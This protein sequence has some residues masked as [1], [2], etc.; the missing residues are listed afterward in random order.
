MGAATIHCGID[1]YSAYGFVFLVT[2]PLIYFT[3]HHHGD[4]CDKVSEE[5]I[6]LQDMKKILKM[7]SGQQD[8]LVYHG[9][10]AA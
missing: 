8:S 9:K 3:V 5:Q 7:D 6:Q 2:M 4:S 10:L 1:N